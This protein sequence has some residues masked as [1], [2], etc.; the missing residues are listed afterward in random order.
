MGICWSF[1]PTPAPFRSPPPAPYSAGFCLL[2][3]SFMT[4]RDVVWYGVVWPTTAVCTGHNAWRE[5]NCFVGGGWH[6]SPFAQP[7]PL[8]LLGRRAGR[9]VWT[10]AAPPAV[11]GGGGVRPQHT[12][13]KMIPTSR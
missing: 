10:G 1:A 6:G 11:P 13:L 3:P 12:L 4:R 2:S 9:G 5:E 8:P 7:P